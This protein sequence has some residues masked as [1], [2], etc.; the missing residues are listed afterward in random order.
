MWLTRSVNHVK[1]S[2]G[3]RYLFLDLSG[4]RKRPFCGCNTARCRR[5]FFI[6][7]FVH[8]C[9]LDFTRRLSYSRLVLLCAD[10]SEELCFSRGSWR[11]DP[12]P[13]SQK[14]VFFKSQLKSHNPSQCCSNWNPIPIFLLFFFSHESQSQCTKS[15]FPASKKGESQLLFNPF[16][17]LLVVFWFTQFMFYNVYMPLLI[18]CP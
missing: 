3:R 16:T 17:T 1:Q 9:Y 7:L 13:I 2:H 11:G 12:N 18:Q 8:L 14:I 10:C 4:G 6:K 15:H 5:S